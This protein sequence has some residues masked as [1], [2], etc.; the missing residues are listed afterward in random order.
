MKFTGAFMSG[1]LAVGV[2]LTSGC[3]SVSTQGSGGLTRVFV[4]APPLGAGSSTITV[5]PAKRGS[6]KP[7]EKS[8]GPSETPGGSAANTA[9]KEQTI[10][11]TNGEQRSISSLYDMSGARAGESIQQPVMR[12]GSKPMPKEKPL[13]VLYE[14]KKDPS[15]DAPAHQDPSSDT[16]FDPR[17]AS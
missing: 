11:S 12:S 9:Q 8:W 1:V 10:A 7:A 4:P 15:P 2:I 5:V 16:S 14:K 6:T 3:A 13:P 17:L